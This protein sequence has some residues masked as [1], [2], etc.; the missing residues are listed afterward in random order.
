MQ[1]AYKKGETDGILKFVASFDP[2]SL[3]VESV[4]TATLEVSEGR[5]GEAAS[6]LNAWIGSCCLMDDHRLAADFAQ[7]L[8]EAF[9]DLEDSN[10]IRPDTVTYCLA[11]TA[12]SRYPE[13]AEMAE[14]VMDQATRKSK[15]MAGGKRRKILA[16]SRR[17]ETVLNASEVEEDL[18]QLCGDEFSVLHESDE[19][20]VVNKP[21]GIPC[22]HKKTT[23]AGKVRKRKGKEAAMAE[24]ISLE[25]AFISCNVPLST[26]N[27]EAL[28]LVHRLDRGSSGCIVLAKTD[29]MHALLV[30]EF[31]LR[32]TEKTYTTV[33]SPAPDMSI[34]AE[35]TIALPVDGRP[36]KSQYRIKQRFGA[37]AA[38]LEFDIYTG[39]KHQIRVHASEGLSSPVYLDTMYDGENNPH[40]AGT[41]EQQFLLHASSLSI[42]KFGI[43]AEAPLPKWWSAIIDSFE[44]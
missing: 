33:V 23:T 40:A 27:P 2:S 30:S 22:F 31:F 10:N 44:T 34:A 11:Y 41:P 29:E 16:A 18:R 32:R 19:L 15:K 14:Y 7:E 21:S 39:R 42:P 38:L 37:S 12:L 5:S 25:D 8:M 43:Q 13:A 4:V 1:E 36:A 3:D 26:L 24:D 20:L 9:E 17:K 6:I 28:G 35:G